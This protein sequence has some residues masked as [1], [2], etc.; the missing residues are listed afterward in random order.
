MLDLDGVEM[1]S[2]EGHAPGIAHQNEGVGKIFGEDME[3]EHGTVIVDD[4][5]RAGNGLF[6]HGWVVLK[7][8]ISKLFRKF[9]SSNARLMRNPSS[10]DPCYPDRYVSHF[11]F[12]LFF[13]LLS[14]TGCRQDDWTDSSLDPGRR[15]DALLK[16]MTLEEKVGQLL[17][18]LGWPVYEKVSPDSVPY[19]GTRARR[20]EP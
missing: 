8:Q 14:P 4:Q 7:K 1:L 16:E 11:L 18:P 17:C 12:I 5:F 10:S 9:T 2:D 15:A 13:L 20:V 3:M 6:I 19:M